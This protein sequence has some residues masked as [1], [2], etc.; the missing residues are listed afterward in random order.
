MGKEKGEYVLK[1]EGI[2]IETKLPIQTLLF[3]EIMEGINT[4]SH[5]EL[6]AIIAEN[7]K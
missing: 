5:L 3:M 1:Q 4:H 2:S 6:E 7:E